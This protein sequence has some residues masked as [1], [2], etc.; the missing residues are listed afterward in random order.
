M[1][2]KIFFRALE[3]TIFVGACIH[4]FFIFIEAVRT[5]NLTIIHMAS[6]LDLNFFFPIEYTLTTAVL[7]CLPIVLIFVYFLY[8]EKKSPQK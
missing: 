7:S 3:K 2:K 6:I 4:L 8:R 1:A 5:G